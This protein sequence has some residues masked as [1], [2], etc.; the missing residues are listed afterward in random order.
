MA[1]ASRTGIRGLYRDADGGWRLDLRWTDTRTGERKRYREKLPTGTPAVAAKRR[2]QAILADVVAGD[3][4]PNR[5]APA[6]LGAAFERWL[7]HCA[8]HGIKSVAERRTHGKAWRLFLGEGKALS[9]LT[10]S[11]VERFKETLRG[12]QR[13]PATVNRHTATLKNF[14]AW[15][16]REGLIE[17]GRAAE[18]REVPAL[19]EPE[20]RVRYLS[21]KE[22]Q[23]VNEK[24]DGWLR[25]I[26]LA[27]KFT[28]ARLGEI[29]GLRWRDVDRSAGVLRFTRT[30]TGRRREV[31]I[32]P[33][34]AA[35][36]DASPAAELDAFVFAVPRRQ[37]RQADV[38]RSEDLRRRDVASKAWATFAAAEG[39]RDLH[40]HDLR[41]HAA[42]MIRR[43]GGGLDTVAKVLGHTNVRT[44]ARYAHVEVEDTRAFLI[45]A[46]F[47]QP[48]PTA[49]R[50]DRTAPRV[51]KAKTA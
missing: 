48:L 43:A 35:I 45:A 40:A 10:T 31:A 26:A 12:R 19:R 24:L 15:A 3:F 44:A 5:E 47:A 7:T 51:N 46:S 42:T 18:L 2:A 34:L 36:L 21:P 32:V 22:E 29:T 50:T 25:P 16:A 4:D 20:G 17:R 9:E 23:T 6:A 11:D 1:R 39:L 38:K 28:G 41:H 14:L 8:T 49:P 27:C 33:V 30:K 13:S 37:T